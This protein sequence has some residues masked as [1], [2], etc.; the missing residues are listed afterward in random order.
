MQS[1]YTPG[2]PSL[3]LESVPAGFP[4]P[5][6]GYPEDPLDVRE[7]LVKNPAATFFVRAEGDSMQGAGIFSGDILVVDRSIEASF[8]VVIVAVLNNEFTVKRLTRGVDG[9]VATLMPENPAYPP[10]PISADADFVVW[11]VVT[12]VLHRPS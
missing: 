10:I 1:L 4:S 6:E 9:T 12:Y 5:A 11:G 8:G 7:L 3:F 2:A